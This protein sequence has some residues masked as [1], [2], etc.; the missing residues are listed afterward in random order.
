MRRERE[1]NRERCDKE[2]TRL[3]KK[4]ISKFLMT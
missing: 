3:N 4:L 2:E 1:N